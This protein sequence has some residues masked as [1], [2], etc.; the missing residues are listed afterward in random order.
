MEKRNISCLCR[1]SNL[2]PRP[3][4]PFHGRYTVPGTGWLT[5]Q[6][7]VCSSI[8]WTGVC[9][10][11][12]LEHGQRNPYWRTFARQKWEVLRLSRLGS[13][14]NGWRVYWQVAAIWKNSDTNRDQM[15][16]PVV[17]GTRTFSETSVILD[18]RF[19]RFGE[20]WRFGVN[21]HELLY[22]EDGAVDCFETSGCLRTTRC[23]KS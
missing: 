6:T 2:I 5:G 21:Q 11:K 8:H 10:W 7:R 18:L 23:Y 13:G 12:S 14:H 19:W 22:P 3:F 20:S 15:I 17:T 1:E 16:I 4:S 9:L